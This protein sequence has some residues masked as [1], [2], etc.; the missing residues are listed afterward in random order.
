MALT[1]VSYSMIAGSP[2][3]AVDFGVDDTGATDCSS[4]L[5][6]AIDA[7]TAAGNSLFIGSG[8]FKI[9]NPVSITCSIQGLGTK[10]TKL[11]L[12]RGL[13]INTSG[14]IVQGVRFSSGDSVLNTETAQ[15]KIADNVTDVQIL[16]C[17][18]GDVVN[19]NSA[20]TDTAGLGLSL[21]HI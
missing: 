13:T 7:A 17:Q 4:D 14:V 20:Y 5:Q 21:I 8:T 11:V 19:T 12:S 10:N 1:K 15:V 6:A 9:S 18:F 3:S 16:D 2:A